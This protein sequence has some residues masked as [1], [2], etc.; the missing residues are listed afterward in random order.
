MGFTSSL[1]SALL[2][3]SA[4]VLAEI[5]LPLKEPGGVSKWVL[6]QPLPLAVILL[7]AGVV[8][9]YVI[10][11][12]GKEKQATRVAAL[13][14][15]LAALV[16]ATGTFVVTEQ[17]QLKARTRELVAA[18][19]KADSTRVGPLLADNAVAQPWGLSKSVTLSKMESHLGR[20]ITIKEH[21]IRT[22]RAA[23]DRPGSARTQLRVHVVADGALYAGP[24]GSWWMLRWSKDPGGEWR[25]VEIEMQ[26]LDGVDV[27]S[28]RP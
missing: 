17:E 16:Y 1:G 19:A 28:I 4:G 25:V 13:M 24:I 21:T 2:A 15:T 18:V 23:V 26:Q 9:W 7:L 22:L 27:G 11:G 10:R 14:L 12:K 6:E 5:P 20:S 3:R 8:L